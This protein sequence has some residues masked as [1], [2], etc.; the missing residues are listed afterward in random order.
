MEWDGGDLMWFRI[1]WSILVVAGAASEADAKNRQVPAEYAT[2]NGALDASVPGDTVSVSPG[3]Y[4]DSEMRSLPGFGPGVSCAFLRGGVTLRS[5]DGPEVTTLDLM[6]VGAP[7][8]R[9]VLGVNLAAPT[10]VEGFT[11]VGAPAGNSGLGTIY[12]E[13]LTI[14]HC[15]FRDLN[16]QGGQ[17]PG[18]G[19]SSTYTDLRVE[20]CLFE[21]CHASTGGAIDQLYGRIWILRSVIRGCSFRAVDLNGTGSVIQ[22]AVIQDCV[23]EGNWASLG[24]GAIAA[25]D[26]TPDG[27]LI[28]RCRFVGNATASQGGGAVGLQG[29]YPKTIRDC[30]F[31]DNRSDSGY[32]GAL[33][34]GPGPA[35]VTGNTFWGNTAEVGAAIVIGTF[36]QSQSVLENNII[37]GSSGAVGVS[38]ASGM[39]VSSCNVFWANED[40]DVSGFTLDPTDRII[41]PELC[42]PANGDLTLQSTSPCLPEHSDGCELIGALGVGCGTVSITAESWGSIKSHYR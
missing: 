5:T 25:T 13:E 16:A 31:V 23:F 15:V 14:R 9:V 30:V 27:V 39:V 20:D 6:Q 17:D 4:T 2:I 36:A 42:D 10:A 34:F 18:G 19:I 24:G 40:G 8:G 3:T 28:E 7:Y 37:A 22:G 38:L 41:D 29:W 32:A 1:C 11:I 35:T 26:F 21:N 33:T 12:S